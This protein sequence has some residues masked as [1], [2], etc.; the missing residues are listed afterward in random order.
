[1]ASLD[2]NVLVRYLVQDDEGQLEQVRQLIE[3][4]VTAREPLH[5]PIS[6]AP[7]LEWVLRAGYG[8]DKKIVTDTYANLLRSMELK[9]ESESAVEIA[10]L[11][12]KTY[13]AD[14]ADCLHTALAGEANHAPLFT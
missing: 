6:V 4:Q 14:F 8:F 9:F 12:Y 1:M 13:T 7:E 2:T 11:Y 5:M 10:L 3:Q